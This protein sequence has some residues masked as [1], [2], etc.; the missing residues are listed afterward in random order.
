[1]IMPQWFITLLII[2]PTIGMLFNI[3]FLLATFLNER[4]NNSVW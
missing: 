3:I 1:M 2:V 4:K